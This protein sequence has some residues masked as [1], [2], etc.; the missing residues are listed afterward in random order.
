[1]FFDCRATE[2][3]IHLLLSCLD[4]SQIQ[5]ELLVEAPTLTPNYKFLFG[6][7]AGIE[8]TTQF[9]A[10]SGIATRKW[11]LERGEDEDENEEI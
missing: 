6:T 7:S 2:T 9:I 4:Y 5:Q 3:P 1:M 11:H 8:Y 10:K